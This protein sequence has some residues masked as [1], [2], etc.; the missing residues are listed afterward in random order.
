M[1]QHYHYPTR[2]EFARRLV[3]KPFPKGLKT[4]FAVLALIGLVTFL[5]GVFTGQERAWHALHFNWLYFTV[6]STAG[7][8]FA[9]VQRIVTGRWSRPIVRFAEGF[10]A[11]VPVAFVILLVILLFGKEHIFTWAGREAITVQEKATYLAPGFFLARGILIFG[12]ITV[13]Q[14]W[15]VWNSVRLDVAVM[16]E[17]GAKWAAGLRAK[18]RAGFGD[19]RREL[20]SQHSLQGKVAIAVCMTFVLGWCVMAWDYSMTLSLH[21]QQTMYAWIVFMGG[22][23]NMIMAVALL[24]M[25][26]RN[27]LGM[28]DLVTIDHFWDL[29]KLGFAFTAFFGY[30]SFSQYLVI[31]YGNMPEETFFY[32][33]R[34]MGV[35]KPV[36]ALIPIFGFVLPFFGLISKAAKVYLPTFVVFAICS[37]IGVYLH[38]YIEVYPSIYGEAASLP[39]GIWEVGITLGYLGVW[40]LCYA[41]FMDAFPVMRVFMMTSPFRDEV[42]VPVD[43]RTMEPLPAHE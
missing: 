35:W 11:F 42:Q 1:S 14:L 23:V 25:W 33:L 24:G 3:N 2:E 22:W 27:H 5:G 34:L 16:P 17:Y 37:L 13:L 39:Y 9:A 43:A 41:A 4:L 36:T 26:W 19:E 15:F 32:R 38:S 12:L 28:K 8:A 29:G 40:G 6:I 18:M 21:F 10:V 20:H 30:I 7:T 31:W